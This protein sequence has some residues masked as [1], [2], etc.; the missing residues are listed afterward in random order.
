M[1][2]KAIKSKKYILLN[3]RTEILIVLSIVVLILSIYIQVRGHNFII[4]DDN[5]YVT[6]NLQVQSGISLDSLS[7]A[8][9]LKENTPMYWHPL[10]WIS[11][12]LDVQI[13]GL[14]PGMH[15]IVNLILHLLNSVM[16]FYVLKRMTGEIWK[17]AIVALLFAAHPLNV[18]SVAWIAARKNVLSTLFWMLTILFYVRYTERPDLKKYVLTLMVFSL[19]LLAKPMLMTIPF[20]LLLLDFWPIKRLQI[21]NVCAEKNE[22]PKPIGKR[23]KSKVVSLPF[24]IL[25]KIPFILIALIVTSIAALSMQQSNIYIS[26]ESVP[27]KLRVEN[28]LVSYII[29]I[30]RMIWPVNLA[31]FY[32]FPK[33]IAIWKTISAG[34]LLVSASW[35]SFYFY[36][37]K[38]Y[39][40]VGWF[41]FIGA[42]VPVIGLVQAGLWPAMAD[43]WAYVP[44]IGIFIILCWMMPE[45]F[46]KWKFK[47]YS[48]TIM[49]FIVISFL[50]FKTWSQVQYWSN[51]ITL[52]EYTVKT[53]Q[54]NS[55]AQNNLG[56]L[57]AMRGNIARAAKHFLETLRIDPKNKSAGN[58]L[59]RA[60]FI[61]GRIDNAIL[62][63]KKVLD[64][65]PDDVNAIKNLALLY[66]KKEQHEMSILVLKRWAQLQMDNPEPC[67]Y[68]AQMY[69]VINREDEA[70]VWLKKAIEKGYNNWELIKKDKR[71]KNIIDNEYFKQKMISR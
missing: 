49:A 10:T 53:T 11:H 64:I 7:W 25:E 20:V 71:F 55:V 48:L 52:F 58:N 39:L 37:R 15:H 6:E 67:Y 13:Y 33:T 22:K 62:Q 19:G 3:I 34:I 61:T 28:A 26:F 23:E 47:K 46:G 17:S 2:T 59:G 42:L 56:S 68:I 51:S 21:R 35:L 54:N 12:M 27:L 29:Y 5:V 31:V 40:L 44:L 1:K 60:Y 9:G 4:F 38:P 16:L 65:Y 24:I 18:E 43:R 36:R 30:F 66:S 69:A 45:I 70:N 8:F 50:M 14:H 63:Y 41:W 32:P 57:Y